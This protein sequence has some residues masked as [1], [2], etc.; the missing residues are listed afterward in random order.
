MNTLSQRPGRWWSTLVFR[1]S[2]V[3]AAL[4]VPINLWYV[5]ANKSPDRL[6]VAL[7]TQ[8][9]DDYTQWL[10]SFLFLRDSLIIPS[11]FFAMLVMVAVLFWHY[12]KF[13]PKNME[14]QGEGDV[15]EWWSL[16]ERVNHAVMVVAFFL[17][18]LSGLTITFGK[19]LPSGVLVRALHELVGFVFAPS[20][21]LMLVLWF[22][23]GL[24]KSYDAEW[25]K[26][27][28]GYLGEVKVKLTAGK[29][30]AGQKLFYWVV[31]LS[32]I[33]LTVSGFALFLEFGNPAERRM[34][35]V[36]HFYSMIP[37]ILMV[38]LHV[39]LAVWG[40]KGALRGMIDGKF[41]KKAA[42]TYHKEALK[43]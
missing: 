14:I 27:M 36:L 1:S 43:D 21:A 35:L 3:L 13:G 41:S 26:H 25:F 22:K 37:L 20:L 15:I 40:V 18:M 34:W 33:I 29:F 24:F 31:I 7:Q 9:G 17:L 10:G 8:F 42:E 19:V 38:F 23:N 28:G 12:K 2:V 4:L 30:N 16:T 11:F 5:F 32:G 39:Y 6:N